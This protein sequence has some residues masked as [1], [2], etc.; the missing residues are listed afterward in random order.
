L[1]KGR[2][3][4]TLLAGLSDA[5]GNPLWPQNRSPAYVGDS[6]SVRRNDEEI[7]ASIVRGSSVFVVRWGKYVR[8]V[9]LRVDFIPEQLHFSDPSKPVLA[10]GRVNFNQ[11]SPTVTFGWGNLV[12]ENKHFTFPVEL[13]I[14]FQGSPKSTLGL[15]GNV[16]TQQGNP[17]TCVDA[18]TD[19]NVQA[20]MI[21]EQNK[22]NNSMKPFKFY[23]IVS[24]GFGYKF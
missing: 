22:I 1:R 11:V 24:F 9:E 7:R 19:P 15:T 17:A 12:R 6:I 2:I 23:P 21:S 14:A 20:N 4:L 3:L 13:G 10:S 5:T 16:C 8:A 18:A